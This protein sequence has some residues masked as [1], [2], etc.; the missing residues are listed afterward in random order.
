MERASLSVPR[1][2]SAET[3]IKSGDNDSQ[4]VS[5]INTCDVMRVDV[6]VLLLI[7]RR[8][9]E[10]T[11]DAFPTATVSG[12][13]HCKLHRGRV[14]SGTGPSFITSAVRQGGR[15]WSEVVGRGRQRKCLS[16]DVLSCSVM[17]LAQEDH[18]AHKSQMIFSKL[19]KWSRFSLLRRC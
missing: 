2:F 5:I 11:A 13:C 8:L 12:T 15:T 17:G 3:H 18:R 14:R 9:S 4:L 1:L 16:Q 6:P 10:P 19:H 7:Q